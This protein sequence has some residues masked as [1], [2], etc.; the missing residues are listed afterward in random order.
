MQ[1]FASAEFV[2]QPT[3]QDNCVALIFEIRGGEMVQ[4]NDA[5]H[6]DDGSG[7]YC[8][9]WIFVIKTD[10]AAGYRRVERAACVADAAHRL[11]ELIKYFGIVGIAEVQAI[12]Y[13]G[14]FAAG[15][16]DV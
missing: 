11:T 2:C 6:A 15:A 5:D 16:Y 1:V 3:E 7:V 10:V 9:G 12:R 4:V 8:A 14:R 13:R